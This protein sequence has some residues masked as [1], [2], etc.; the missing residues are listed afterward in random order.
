[1]SLQKKII[2]FELIN[3]DLLT[4]LNKSNIKIDSLNSQID[5]M[6]KKVTFYIPTFNSNKTLEP[7]L[8]SIINQSIVPSEIIIIDANKTIEFSKNLVKKIKKTLDITIKIIHQDPVNSNIKKGLAAAR[9][10]AINNSK[11][12][13]IASCDSDVI[14]DQYWLEYNLIH[15]LDKNVVGICGNMI[16]RKTTKFDKWRS[17]HMKQNWGKKTITNP[18][19]LFGSNNIFRRK[20]LLQNLYNEKFMTNY[21]DVDMSNILKKKGSILIYEARAKA[22]HIKQDNL[23]SLLDSYYNWTFYSYPKPKN[24]INLILK[25]CFFNISKSLKL[26]I[27]D[28]LNLEFDMFIISL[29]IYFH[30]SYKD[31]NYFLNVNKN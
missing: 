20:N 26:I 23:I 14:L 30:N 15:F 17:I 2:K 22:I 3:T 12:E 13:F 1:M 9:N 25:I 28:L 18:P 10:I 21:E 31:M 19:F 29:K 7:C 6:K 16:E 8:N 4:K 27:N 11:Y 24:L 5:K